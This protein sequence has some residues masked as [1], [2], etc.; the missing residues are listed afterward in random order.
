MKKYA[1][2]LLLL[3]LV[4]TGCSDARETSVLSP[5]SSAAIS[6]G[7]TGMHLVVETVWQ[8]G[9]ESKAT[10]QYMTSEATTIEN[11]F[12]SATNNMGGEFYFSHAQVMILDE[13]TARDGVLP[14]C[15][16]LCDRRDARLGIRLAVAR[17][18]TA[19]EVLRAWAPGSEIPG[20]AL[21]R[22]LSQGEKRGSGIDMPL[23]RFLNLILAEDTVKTA[24]P[25]VSIG[26]D[27]QA[28][29]A[30]LALFEGDK[31]IGFSDKGAAHV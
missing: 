21:G 14:I 23:F 15:T 12:A 1:V 18:A 3:S 6:N 11:L 17:D 27:G 10:P 9:S 29:P 28:V 19:E 20:I 16:Y 25:A 22:M 26:Q 24:L 8:E 31:L 13:Q 7:A 4:L 5:V 2:I 30:G